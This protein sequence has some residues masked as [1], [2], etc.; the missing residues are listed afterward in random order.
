V[1]FPWTCY[2]ADD[3]LLG[4]VGSTSLSKS[5]RRQ[6]LCGSLIMDRDFL[7][8]QKMQ[9]VT[10]GVVLRTDSYDLH[11][12]AFFDKS[13]LESRFYS[14]L[15][16]VSFSSY[17]RFFSVFRGGR[18][19]VSYVPAISYLTV[20]VN[21]LQLGTAGEEGNKGPIANRARRVPTGSV[22]CY[23]RL[24]RPTRRSDAALS[25]WT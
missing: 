11:D 9:K 12:I 21:S 8:C 17:G 1:T 5:T 10:Y 25:G 24:R 15:P 4:S 13:K 19:A 7:R 16:V 6:Y 23:H 14:L 2:R 22:D 3:V 18:P 20:M